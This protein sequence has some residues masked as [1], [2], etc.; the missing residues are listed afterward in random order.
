MI[1]KGI[2]LVLGKK[3]KKAQQLVYTRFLSQKKKGKINKDREEK[4]G[5]GGVWF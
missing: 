5:E 2:P 1:Q 3:K 4:K